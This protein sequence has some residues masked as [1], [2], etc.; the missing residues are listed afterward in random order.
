VSMLLD[1][2]GPI[3]EAELAYGR[4]IEAWLDRYGPGLRACLRT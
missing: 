4:A 1:V 2:L 3:A